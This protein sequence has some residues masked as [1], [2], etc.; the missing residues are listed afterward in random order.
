MGR[1]SLKA[2]LGVLSHNG[3]WRANGR[4]RNVNGGAR[5]TPAYPGRSYGAPS[6]CRLDT[7]GVCYNITS[8]CEER[9]HDRTTTHTERRR[10]SGFGVCR[11]F[12]PPRCDKLL[13]PVAAL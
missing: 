13:K 8:K 3:K 5:S 6:G 11:G 2:R 7:T 4:S 9:S 10:F 1:H 12:P